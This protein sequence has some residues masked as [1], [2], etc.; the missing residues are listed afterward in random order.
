MSSAIEQLEV[1]MAECEST[2]CRQGH[3]AMFRGFCGIA[4]SSNGPSA[5]TNEHAKKLAIFSWALDQERRAA[6]E[7]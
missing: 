7:A 2:P 6:Y 3:K 1:A 5:W 4:Q